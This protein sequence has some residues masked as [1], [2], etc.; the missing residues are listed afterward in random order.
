[1]Y[2]YIYIYIYI[3]IYLYIYISIYLYI[4]ISIQIGFKAFQVDAVWGC[5]VLFWVW[6][7]GQG[8][9]LQ[10]VYSGPKKAH[11]HKHFMGISLP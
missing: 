7:L 11:K 9:V 4:Y 3:S 5:R 10:R 1:M 8:L 2:M 6:D